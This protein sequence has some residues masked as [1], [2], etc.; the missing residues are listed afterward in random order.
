M[1]PKD[2]NLR[3]VTS[4]W[5]SMVVAN[6]LE[7]SGQDSSSILDITMLQSQMT[8]LFSILRSWTR[9]QIQTHVGI[10]KVIPEMTILQKRV[11][12]LKHLTP[13]CTRLKRTVLTSK[14]QILEVQSTWHLQK[15]VWTAALDLNGQRKFALLMET[16]G[17]VIESHLILFV[18]VLENLQTMSIVLLLLLVDLLCS[19]SLTQLRKLLQM[20]LLIRI[21]QTIFVSTNL[22]LIE[23]EL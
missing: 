3:N 15:L 18:L 12:R 9:L 6:Q 19:T 4:T 22:R 8:L 20:Q 14:A 5:S 21:S 13:F 23:K 1:S 16:H 7:W 10:L 11:S 2:A 17:V